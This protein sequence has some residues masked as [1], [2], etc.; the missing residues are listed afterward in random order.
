LSLKNDTVIDN[1]EYGIYLHTAVALTFG[2]SLSEWNDIYDNGGGSSG[3]DLRNGSLDIHAPYVYWGTVVGSEIKTKIW[4]KDDDAGLGSV[5]YSPWSNA[6]HDQATGLWMTAELENGAK[7]GSGDVYLEWTEY[8]GLEGLDHFVV[9]RSTAA[10]TKGDS[11]AGTTD[12]WYTDMGVVGTV[13]TDYYYTAE[14]VDSLGTRF[15]SN[16]AGEYDLQLLNS[17]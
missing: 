15:E 3:R 14:L 12:H 13:G 16:Q 11:L 4:D 1:S 17:P 6:D 10:G 7:S 2:S 8:C 9:Y 5:C